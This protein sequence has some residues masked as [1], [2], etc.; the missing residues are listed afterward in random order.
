M[1]SISVSGTSFIRLSM[2]K[3]G[4]VSAGF[5]AMVA[6]CLLVVGVVLSTLLM[7][8]RNYKKRWK[9]N[10]ERGA[11]QTERPLMKVRNS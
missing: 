2:V 11:S 1:L 5:G 3:D 9:Y 8:I 7:L 6:V 10:R 4:P